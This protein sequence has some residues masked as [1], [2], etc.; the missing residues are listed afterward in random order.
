[1]LAEQFIAATAGARN[2]TTLDETARLLWRAHSEG[3]LADADAG[4]VSEALQTRRRAFPARRAPT[5]PVTAE[6][7]PG[8][9]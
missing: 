1:M 4:A 6:A 5:S 8:P 3:H 9:S 7:S 2:S